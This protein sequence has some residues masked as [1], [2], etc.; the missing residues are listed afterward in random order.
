MTIDR[1]KF[2]SQIN[3]RLDEICASK[4]IVMLMDADARMVDGAPSRELIRDLLPT[5]RARLVNSKRTKN[6]IYG[7]ED[8]IHK[9]EN[10]EPSDMVI[11]YGFISPKTAGVLY[12]MGGGED[13]LG[14]VVVDR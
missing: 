13:L 8:L 9:L 2:L 1:N 10:K 3:E 5:L 11:G 7:L 12:F 14:G 6:P 4:A